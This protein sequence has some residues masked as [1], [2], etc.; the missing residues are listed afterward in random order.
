MEIDMTAT[1]DRARRLL[2]DAERATVDRVHKQALHEAET[3]LE[4]LD[5]LLE[6]FHKAANV[7]GERVDFKQALRLKTYGEA[8]YYFA[9][10]AVALI[11][12][13]YGKKKLNR[14]G[15]A[16]GVTIVRNHLIE[17]ADD[18]GIMSENWILD[19]PEGLIL[20]PFGAAHQAHFDRGLRPN[21][22]ELRAAIELLLEATL[23]NAASG[24]PITSTG[25]SGN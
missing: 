13:V 9:H 1:F 20:K 8:L 14:P 3:R 17:H 19:I 23:N 16:L 4:Q 21:M 25:A 12:N 10:R 18:S 2:R 24:A 7:A 11:E 15:R 6:E 5:L 22:E